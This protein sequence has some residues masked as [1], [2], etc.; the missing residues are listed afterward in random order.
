MSTAT[1]LK[2]GD[3]W[4]AKGV[5]RGGS[6]TGSRTAIVSCPDCGESAALSDHEIDAAGDV[7]PSLVCPAKGCSFH[8]HVRLV[9]WRPRS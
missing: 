9:G 8:E 6:R 3:P 7:T 4:K 5:W 1:E 2:Q